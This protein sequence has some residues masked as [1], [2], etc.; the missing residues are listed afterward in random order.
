VNFHFLC[1]DFTQNPGT[2]LEESYLKF[3]KLNLERFRAHLNDEKMKKQLIKVR[4]KLCFAGPLLFGQA[5]AC[6]AGGS[7]YPRELHSRTRVQKAAQV[8]RRM[9][10]SLAASPLAKIPSRAKPARELAASPQT[11]SRS[12]PLPPATQASQT[13]SVVFVIKAL[14]SQQRYWFLQKLLCVLVAGLVHV[15][16]KEDM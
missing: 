1:F 15:Y 6:V 2:E 12:H 11:V 9:G 10:R 13:V 8:A 16:N 14:L 3:V 4:F 7:G 5:V